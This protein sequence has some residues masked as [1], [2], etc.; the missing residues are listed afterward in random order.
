MKARVQWM[1][2][3]QMSFVAEADSGHALVMD[4]S[5]EIGGRNIGP[6]PMELLLMGLGGCSSIDVVMILQKSRQDIRDCVVELS[7]QRADQEP[8]VFTQIH[9]H[10]VVSGKALDPKR[11]AH[12]IN[13]SAEKY[14]S[15]SIMLGKTAV[16]THDYEVREEG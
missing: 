10:F 3:E 13:L 16:I 2:P 15:A 5:V 9:L 8:K 12:A 4:G 14:C 6:R 11:V 7:A 1:G